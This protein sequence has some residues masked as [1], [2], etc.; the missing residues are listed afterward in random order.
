MVKNRRLLISP[1]PNE[2]SGMYLY[3]L[4]KSLS[5]YFDIVNY[6]N[7]R[8]P[9]PKEL[10]RYLF[11][12]DIF[13]LNWIENEPNK[14]NGIFRYYMVQLFL[15]I[16]RL[17]NK[18]I[19]WTFHNIEPHKKRG[20]TQSRKIMDR[21]KKK[22]DLI[23]HHTTES[24]SLTEK[25]KS[26][27]FFHPFETKNHFNLPP[28]NHEYKY[29]ILIWGAIAP[30]K[31]IAEFLQYIETDKYMSGLKIIVAGKV[32]DPNYKDKL[33]K[34]LSTNIDFINRFHTDEEIE[35]LHK[36]TRYVFYSHQGDSVLN[37][38][39]LVVSMGYGADIIGPDK[40][41]FKE[42]A[43]LGLIY[44]YSAFEEIPCIL[45]NNKPTKKDL[46]R[47]FI[48]DHTWDKFAEGFYLQ[49]SQLF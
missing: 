18:K 35:I 12:A 9:A 1:T 26:F 48:R 34:S 7:K 27:C 19:I 32:N 2:K 8:E 38:G 47:K 16:A 3:N 43:K 25:G 40:G 14:S 10:F 28:A 39:Q 17:F 21:L 13:L 31:G 42:L 45:K 5:E 49:V 11:K 6:G 22:S 36:E 23:V 4:A 37:S 24:F 46:C 20:I 15:T 30:Y 41:A 33:E 29:D 44:T